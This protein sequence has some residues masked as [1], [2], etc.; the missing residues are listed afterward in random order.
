MCGI[1]GLIGLPS[2]DLYSRL[3]RLRHR[4]PDARGVWRTPDNRIQLGHTRLSILDLSPTG[5]QPMASSCGRYVV[6]F[7]GEIY[8]HR[9]IRADLEQ[10]GI[11][12]QSTSDTEV[13]LQAYIRWGD[14]FLKRLNGM[15]AF[16]LLDQGDGQQKPSLLLA[17]DRIGKK[18][19]YYSHQG[20]QFQFASEPKAL[21]LGGEID[22]NALNY[23]L[24]LGYIPSELCFWKGVKKLPPAHAARLDLD[25]CQVHVWRYWELPSHAPESFSSEEIA[26]RAEALFMDAVRI[27][28][29]ADVPV[30]VFLSG[31]MDSSLVVAAAAQQSAQPVKTFTI[32]AASGKY[33]ES[34][35]AKLV[36]EHFRTDHHVLEI[37]QPTVAT[38]EE[39]APFLDEPL[40]DSS[41]IPTYLV[42]KL[43]RQHVT[44][45]LG[46]DGG[47]ELFGGYSHY[48]QA[49]QDQAWFGRLPQTL[50][51]LAAEGAAL[52]PAG[53]KGRN[54]IAS[55][56]HGPIQGMIWGTSY[57]DATLRKRLLSTEGLEFL[58]GPLEAPELW[59]QAIWSTAVNPVDKMTRLDF[60]TILPDA[61]M[62]KVD[63]A[64]MMNGLEGR[65]PFLDYRLAEFA[66]AQIPDEWKVTR[67]ETRRIQR[68]LARR[69]LPT[70][71]PLNRKQGFSIPIDAI[72]RQ[73]WL[74]PL[75]EYMEFL[76]DII[77]RNE[78]QSLLRGHLQGRANGGRLFAL[79]MLAIA[80]KNVRRSA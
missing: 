43:T 48:Q 69:M 56:R 47:D 71:L 52:L 27:R 60:A 15:F 29:V 32:A 54:R 67:H 13:L 38:L 46:G 55:L 12:F 53:I 79:L 59:K 75:K 45:A 49:L 14:N 31:G 73:D 16:A 76:P 42:S 72:F 23:Y 25:D 10:Q 18:P 44:V 26:D 19:L 51:R 74:E 34:P 41:Q 6:T 2:V 35:Y 39:M 64:S 17:R 4:G 62:V 1:L 20:H 61:Y 57:F 33:D 66:F 7:N 50:V 5:A 8:N 36:A 63:R 22:L 80:L 24:A 9:E 68:I 77:N 28:M 30:G 37:S 70:Q 65:S 58:D 11:S 21:D 40:A 3:G 78:V